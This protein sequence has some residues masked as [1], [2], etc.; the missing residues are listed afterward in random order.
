VEDDGAT[1]TV[2]W[3]GVVRGD[4]VK[5]LSGRDIINS[6][7]HL[8]N[9]NHSIRVSRLTVTTKENLPEK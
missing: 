9:K 1:T 7:M 5:V 4:Q 6:I 2:Y 3:R 8:V